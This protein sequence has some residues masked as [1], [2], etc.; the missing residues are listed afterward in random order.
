MTI[1]C[2]VLHLAGGK[3]SLLFPASVC[4]LSPEGGWGWVGLPLTPAPGF[5]Q[6]G[7]PGDWRWFL[8]HLCN[9]C[10]CEQ[11]LSP[12]GDSVSIKGLPHSLRATQINPPPPK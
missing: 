6:Q 3:P 2:L 9:S 7:S 12:L 11:V 10:L 1:K 8:S 5:Q 4:D